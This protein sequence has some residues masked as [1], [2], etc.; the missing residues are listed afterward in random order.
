MNQ[1][2]RLLYTLLLATSIGAMPA[3]AD[4][5]DIALPD[6]GESSATIFNQQKER[7]LGAYTV[8][9]LRAAN[10]I[11]DDIELTRYLQ[12][13]IDRLAAAGGFQNEHLKIFLINDPSINAFALPGGYMGVNAGL[14]MASQTES[15]LAA[16][17]AHEITHVTQRHIARSVEASQGAD[18]IT[19]AAIIAAIILSGSDPDVTQ[20]ALGG[21]LAALQQRKINHTRA[22]E[23]EADRIGISL[24]KKAGF[25]PRGMAAFFG[26]L[27]TQSRY[28]TEVPEI[29]RT[30]PISSNR[31][32]EAK[33]RA[34]KW[35]LVTIDDSQQYYLMKERARV[36]STRNH[37]NLQ[38]FYLKA[39]SRNPREKTGFTYGHALLL[40]HAGQHQRA[41]RKLLALTQNDALPPIYAL[42]LARN[43]AAA[44]DISSSNRYFEQIK[45]LYPNDVLLDFQYADSLLKAGQAEKAMNLLLNQRANAY[46]RHR[47]YALLSRAASEM[48][49]HG[50]ANLYMSEHHLVNGRKIEAIRQLRRGLARADLTDYAKLRL[51]ARLAQL[52]AK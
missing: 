31:I 46:T 14:L 6:M 49:L 52:T 39:K 44:G 47:Y 51:E 33:A 24:L 41:Q 38:Q 48:A 3:V 37:E 19:T 5:Q 50:Q 17:L 18:L 16:V 11:L 2:T 43:A 12:G 42:A 4:E 27:E 45:I 9:Q 22:H 36:A 29:L 21:G 23:Y 34:A 13:L 10:Y 25:D 26:R 40:S 28:Y 35:P 8:R 32:S 7:Q 15:E 30:H 20:A 1:L